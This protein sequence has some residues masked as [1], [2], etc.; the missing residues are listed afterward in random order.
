MFSCTT[1][2]CITMLKAFDYVS[3]FDK[4]LQYEYH[5]TVEER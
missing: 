1:L 5:E 4:R 2:S 3:H